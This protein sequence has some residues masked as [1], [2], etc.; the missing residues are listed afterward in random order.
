MA[1]DVIGRI[2]QRQKATCQDSSVYKVWSVELLYSSTDI[3]K[4]NYQRAYRSWF[5]CCSSGNQ[6]AAVNYQGLACE[7]APSY[8][9]LINF[10]FSIWLMLEQCICYPVSLVPMVQHS[11]AF[12]SLMVHSHRSA[13]SCPTVQHI[14]V[15]FPMSWW[16]LLSSSMHCTHNLNQ[17]C[18][19]H[20]IHGPCNC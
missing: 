3:S 10:G 13:A 16:I 12:T 5:S 17:M 9:T 4:R 2:V 8:D 11:R 6:S 7:E 15:H 20:F 14:P 18:Q 1:L 19:Q